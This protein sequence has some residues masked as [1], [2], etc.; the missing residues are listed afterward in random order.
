MIIRVKKHQVSAI[1]A[2]DEAIFTKIKIKFM[3]NS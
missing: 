2:R 1:E 3:K